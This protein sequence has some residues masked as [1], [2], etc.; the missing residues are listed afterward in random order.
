MVLLWTQGINMATEA[1]DIQLKQKVITKPTRAC[2]QKPMTQICI[3]AKTKYTEI[4]LRR[5][6]SH[7]SVLRKDFILINYSASTSISFKTGKRQVATRK[8]EYV[9]KTMLMIQ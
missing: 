1:D 9:I 6:S 5:N 3:S 7:I 8:L 4:K 2:L